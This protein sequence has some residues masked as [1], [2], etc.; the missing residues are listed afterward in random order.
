MWHVWVRGARPVGKARCRW[1]DNIKM[2]VRNIMEG[3]EV[4]WYDSG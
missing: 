4:D 2:H 1:E 3:C